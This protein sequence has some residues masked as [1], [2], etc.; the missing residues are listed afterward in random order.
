MK[1]NASQ[2]QTSTATAESPLLQRLERG[3]L[4][5]EQY[6]DARVEEAIAPF[7]NTLTR[8]Q[9]DFMRTTLRERL[10]LDPAL[11]ELVQRATAGA[12]RS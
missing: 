10:Q 1:A 5:R 8:D 11:V 3:E 9:L 12:P 2:E 6:L 4:T 7:S